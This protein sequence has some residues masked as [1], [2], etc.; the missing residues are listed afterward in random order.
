MSV[1][2]IRILRLLTP[3]SAI[4]SSVSTAIA[5]LTN[6]WLHSIEYMSNKDYQKFSMPPEME[7][8]EKITVSGLWQLC[9]NDP[10][11]KLMHCFVIDYFS[12]EEYS[13]DPNDSTNALPYAA[14]RAAVFIMISCV[15]LL[16]GQ[17]LCFLGHV[18]TRRRVFTFAAGI[19]F[20]IAGLL[21]LA[22]MVIYIS[23]FKAEVGNKLRPKSSFQG[24]MF[25]Y[26]YG[27]SFLFAVSGLILCEIAGTVAIFLY[28]RLHQ[29]KYKIEYE[30][31]QFVMV[32]DYLPTPTAPPGLT[33]TGAAVAVGEGPNS[34]AYCKRHGSRGRR[35]S[36]TRELSRETSPCCPPTSAHYQLKSSSRHGSLNVPNT[37]MPTLSDS[38]RDLTYFNFPPFSRETTCNTVSTSADIMRD[39]SR[40]FMTPQ[41]H[42]RKDNMVSTLDYPRELMP[43]KEFSL[44]T[45]RRTTPV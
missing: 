42:H 38:M 23:T 16:I 28:I 26:R 31:E 8:N 19:A 7:Y 2:S 39:F 45:L 11:Q 5:L 33:T 21:I 10:P 4:S 25:K 29:F 43:R 22:G 36:R 44:E 24:P 41:P 9:H 27:Y 3:L 6:E 15:I 35:Y 13:P 32:D 34:M 40:E 30:R 14:K 1:R 20:I 18:C 17:L 12:N 37:L